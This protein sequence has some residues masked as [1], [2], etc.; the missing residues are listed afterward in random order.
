MDTNEYTRYERA[1]VIGAR[2]LQI[3]AG[4]PVLTKVPKDMHKTLAIAEYEYNAGLTPITVLRPQP[5]R[6]TT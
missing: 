1:R 3:A 4:A 2:A 5:R 6:V